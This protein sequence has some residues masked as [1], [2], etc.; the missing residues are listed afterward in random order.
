MSGAGREASAVRA[1]VVEISEERAESG[2]G[3]GEDAYARFD[4]A[5]DCDVS[6]GVEEIVCD[7]QESDEGNSDDG[8]YSCQN[9][10]G[11]YDT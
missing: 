2:E 4:G 11:E 9:T 8:S 7:G 6:S 3:G 10:H 5:P 1:E